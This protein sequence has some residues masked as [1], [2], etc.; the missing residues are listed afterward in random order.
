MQAPIPTLLVDDELSALETLQGML[1]SCCPQIKVIGT[2]CSVVDALTFC[3]KNT[4]QLVFLDIE[5]PPMGNGFE[6]VRLS[7]PNKFGIIITTAYPDY[8]VSAIQTLQ[9]WGYLI[10]PYEPTELI[11]SVKVALQKLP[12]IIPPPNKRQGI[13]ISDH[14]LGNIVVRLSEILYIVSS[15]S[16]VDIVVFKQNREIRYTVYRSLKDIENEL[17]W[18]EFCRT[19]NRFIVNM[20]SVE[21]YERTGRNGL[22][23]LYNGTQIDIS[24]Q[25]M[26]DFVMRFEAHLQGR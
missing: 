6:F 8:A 5:M 14:R 24:V 3:Q 21:R 7:Q 9:P 13:L 10:K 1:E 17:P 20:A 2:A 19:H 25:K 23:H 4:P 16:T 12:D 15:N 11:A 22:I 18:T 26:D